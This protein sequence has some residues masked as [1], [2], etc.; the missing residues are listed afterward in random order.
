MLTTRIMKSLLPT[1]LWS[2]ISF[3]EASL[4]KLVWDILRLCT[5]SPFALRV[6]NGVYTISSVPPTSELHLDNLLFVP[7]VPVLNH[8]TR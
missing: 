4:A 1:S 2:K 5:V 8:P 3:G 7:K 6:W